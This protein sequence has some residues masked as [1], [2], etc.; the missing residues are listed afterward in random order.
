MS[1]LDNLKTRLQYNG[2]N[3]QQSRMNLDKLRSLKKALLYSYQAATAILEDGR[4]FRCLINP[5]KLKNDYD[6]KIISIP[7][8]DICLGRRVAIEN[9]ETGEIEYIDEPAAIKGKTSNSLE[10][11]GMKAGDVFTWK[12]NNTSWIVYLQRMEE[13]AYFRAEIRQCKYEIEIN[14]KTYKIWAR[15][16]VKDSLIWNTR[17]TLGSWNDIDYTLNLYITK[18]E[19][20]LAFFHRF[21]KIKFNGKPWEVQVVDSIS[22]EGIIE[23]ALK[24]T[25]QNSIQEAVDEE[26]KDI[27]IKDAEEYEPIPDIDEEELPRIEGD[28]VVYPYDEKEY[29]AVNM[30]DGEWEVSNSKKA[31][32]IKKSA[33]CVKLSIVT[34]YSGEVDLI[35]KRTSGE[36]VVF[37]ITIQSL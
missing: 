28:A 12:E 16:P 32:I 8:E 2:G 3:I 34:A 24:E 4:Q 5:D 9:P 17:R 29:I 26:N 23:V 22:T 14:G 6:D 37:K 1:G 19:D 11:I 36:E 15:G 13:T 21:M 35:Y 20:T 31:V 18:N 33:T 10:T 25:Y 27:E 30:E 7:F